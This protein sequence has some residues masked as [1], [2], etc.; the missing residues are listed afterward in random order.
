MT[1]F[2]FQ[3]RYSLLCSFLAIS[4]LLIAISGCVQPEGGNSHGTISTETPD[5][6]PSPPPTPQPTRP[7]YSPGELVDYIAQSGDTLPALAAHFNT[8]EEEIRSAN[9]ILPQDVST[10][11]AGLPLKIPIYYQPFWGSAFQILP[12]NAFVNGPSQIGFT[13]QEFIQNHTGWLNNYHEYAAGEIRDGAGIVE[14]ISTYYSISARLLLAL[15]E[16]QSK[17]LSQS[18]TSPSVEYPLGIENKFYK[19]FYQQMI[20]AA[21]VLNDGYYGWRT[22]RTRSFDHMDGTVE[23]PDPWQNAATVGLQLFF[24]KTLDLQNYQK[25]ILGDGFLKTYMELFGDPWSESDSQIPGS[26]QQP[27]MLLP[28]PTGSTWVLT[29][30]PHTGW[31]SG[32]NPWAALDFAPPLV[33]GGCQEADQFATAVADGIIARVGTA[34]V[35]LDLDGDGDERTGWTV[36][37]LHVKSVD[38]PLL[39]AHIKAGDIIGRPSCEGGTATGTHVHVARK[40]DGEWIAADSAIPFNLEGWIAHN[41]N[42]TYLGTLTR[43]GHVV[44]A[45]VCSSAD[46]QLTSGK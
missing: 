39:G 37:Y 32:G 12:D 29:G 15:I 8:S 7:I 2:V 21:N 17:G 13:V 42:S 46:S 40:F 5:Q 22:G 31:G 9:S 36:L 41:G 28:F 35:V 4:T 30:G 38:L 19:S 34:V 6:S 11:P 44:N 14:Y 27:A 43:A 45:C 20:L 3:K 1:P 26:L 18:G 33:A 10:L 16:Y 24:A 23:F 25:A